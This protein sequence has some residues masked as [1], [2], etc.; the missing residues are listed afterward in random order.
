MVSKDKSH[1][2]SVVFAT[3]EQAKTNKR[4]FTNKRSFV[5]GESKRHMPLQRFYWSYPLNSFSSPNPRTLYLVT[6][7]RHPLHVFLKSRENK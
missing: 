7:I 6:L 1:V 4:G 3:N 2:T 5:V